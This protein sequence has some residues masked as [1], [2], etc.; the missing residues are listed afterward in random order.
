MFGIANNVKELLNDS[1]QSWRTEL[2]SC[3]YV[4]SCEL[5]TNHLLYMDDLKLYGKTYDQ[6]DAVVQTVYTVSEDIGMELGIKKCGILF[7]KRGKVVSADGITLPNGQI[8]KEIDDTGYKYLGI[9]EYD[10][11]K[12]K[13]MKDVFVTEYNRRLKLLLKSKLNGKNKILA[14]NTW[15]VAALRYSFG[16]L[17][18][19]KCQ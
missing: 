6:I 2:T 3:E 4:S 9:L 11:M 5:K 19:R 7:L 16:V 1:M 17:D 13:K 10:N 12:E 8:M 18:W 15:T 14:I